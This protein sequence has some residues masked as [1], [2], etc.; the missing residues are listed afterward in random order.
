[1][2]PPRYLGFVTAAARLSLDEMIADAMSAP[3]QASSS[4]HVEPPDE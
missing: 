3:V 2:L 1:L 4:P